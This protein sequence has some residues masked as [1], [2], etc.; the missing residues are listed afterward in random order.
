MMALAVADDRG[1]GGTAS[2]SS[3]SGS[4]SAAAAAAAAAHARFDR[5]MKPPGAEGDAREDALAA[6][7]QL[8]GEAG[9]NT[10]TPAPAPAPGPGPGPADSPR[11]LYL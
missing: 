5:Q 4:G 3:G 1:G 8:V 10:P 6:A 2:G 9:R 11:R 7:L